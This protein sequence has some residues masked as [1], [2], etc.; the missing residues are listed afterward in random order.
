MSGTNLSIGIVGLPNVGK[1]TLF[2]A[3]VKG[4]TA[5]VA[6]YPFCTIEP[7]IGVVTVPDER[8]AP[9]A[10]TVKTEKIVPAVIKFVDIAGL[11][12]GAHKGEGLGNQFLSH[13][14]ECDAIA[15]VV[16]FFED[17][18]VIDSGAS[19]DPVENAKVIDIELQLADLA[20]VEKRLSSVEK[21]L[22]GNNK[23]AVY[24]KSGLLKIKEK[25]EQGFNAREAELT[26]F[27]KQALKDL[28][29]LTSKAILYIANVS[30]N[31]MKDKKF[32][33]SI[34]DGSLGVKFLPISAKIEAEL[35]DMSE[36]EKK[37]FMGEYG[38]EESG[39]DSLI[40]EAYKTLGL[41]TYFTAGEQEARA[42][43]IKKGFK[44]P[45]AAGVIHTDFERGFIAAE[46]INWKDLVD[47]GGWS[48]AKEKGKVRIEGKEYV[49][50]DGDT[51]L[52]RFNV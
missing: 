1:S 30:E 43:T 5:E 3:V 47:L 32:I 28:A 27:E 31:Q 26:D 41:A 9:L 12:K 18:D 36:E 42:W 25:L 34:T 50:K 38:L 13:I 10:K 15:M 40:K 46:T 16:R 33:N 11:V 20:T 19:S 21:E 2:N 52:F 29:L 45:Q 39:L 17:K 14:R 22:K 48:Q 6:N 4:C 24:V 8:L 44:A 37:E 7:N 23:E 35:S 49:V 51:M